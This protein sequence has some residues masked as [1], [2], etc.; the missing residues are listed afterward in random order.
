MKKF[1]S[2]NGSAAKKLIP[3]VGMLGISAVMLGTSTFAWFTM[4]KEVNV[5]NIQL[6]ATS[7]VN[8]QMS[9]GFGMG[10]TA[11]TAIGTGDGVGLVKAP[12]NDDDSVDWDNVVSFYDYYAAPKLLPASSTTGGSIFYIPD[13][14][15]THQGKTIKASGTAATAS[16]G[17]TLTLLTGTQQTTPNSGTEGRY[18]D[19]PV[20]FRT[21]STDDITLSVA[22][23]AI[24]GTNNAAASA[25]NKLYKAARVAI[26]NTTDG[27]A[28]TSSSNVVL[29]SDNGT[30]QTLANKYYAKNASENP[31]ALT[32][33]DTYTSTGETNRG[34]DAYGAVN[35]YNGSSAVVTIKAKGAT[36]DLKYAG[37]CT[38]TTAGTTDNIYGAATCAMVRVWLEGEDVDCW[39]ATAGQDFKINLKFTTIESGSGS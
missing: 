28:W 9:L 7:P 20:W 25:S 22:A 6:T 10:G 29:P 32:A 21:S 8:V 19:F 18:I 37:N 26:L 13:N 3:A 2:K 14:E 34:G 39:N 36:T 17:G 27:S 12:K 16:T 30:A 1:N 31:L 5:E 38:P 11:L 15:I 33:E 4:S 35:V 24:V 23:T